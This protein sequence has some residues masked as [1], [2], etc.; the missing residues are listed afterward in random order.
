MIWKQLFFFA[1]VFDMLTICVKFCQLPDEP[2]CCATAL[3]K[4]FFLQLRDLT[5]ARTVTAHFHTVPLSPTSPSKVSQPR[6]DPD[7]SPATFPRCPVAADG[8]KLFSSPGL[9]FSHT[10][11]YTLTHTRSAF[12]VSRQRSCKQAL[13]KVLAEK[14]PLVL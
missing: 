8:P 4:F 7:R 3:A 11:K 5:Q 1:C 6:P 12:L 13:V 14:L 9:S 2:K 10:P